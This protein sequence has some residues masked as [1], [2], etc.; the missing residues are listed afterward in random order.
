MLWGFPAGHGRDSTLI[1]GKEIGFDPRAAD[2][3]R[4]GFF[5]PFMVPASPQGGRHARDHR[6]VLDAIVWI[7][8]TGAPWRDLP[9]ELG[10]WN[11]VFR[12]FRR[13]TTSG[14][15][16][17]MLEAL[18]DGDGG[19]RP[20]ADDRQ[21]QRAGT[22][23]C[24]RRKGGAHRQG[25]GRSRGGLTSKLHIRAN[26]HGLP[27]ALHVSAGQEADCSNYDAPMQARDSDPAIMLGDRGYDSDPIREDLRD[28]GATPEIPTRRSRHV[29]HSVSR[30]LYALRSRIECFIN[31]LEC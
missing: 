16:D 8:R 11:S 6:R 14:L 31:R 19:G 1:P 12:Q 18:A 30:P 23:L 15:W 24:Q 13:W 10:A 25:L 7:A 22:P 3:R 2:G 26:A 27:I 4:V 28:R 5:E 20:A 17:V 29:Q 9:G 21:H